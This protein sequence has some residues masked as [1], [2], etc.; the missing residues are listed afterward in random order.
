MK[1][2]LY[3]AVLALAIAAPVTSFA[4]SQ[5]NAPVT[6]AEVKAQLL[7]LEQAGYDPSAN[8]SE[9]P[10][11]LQA[12]QARINAANG[13]SN[14]TVNSSYGSDTS[15]SFNAGHSALPL[16]NSSLYRGH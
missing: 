10:G 15:G 13:Q 14:G 8:D 1:S 6:R 2:A 16:D 5:N 7:Q 3:A 11:N 4:Q 12:A 9:Y